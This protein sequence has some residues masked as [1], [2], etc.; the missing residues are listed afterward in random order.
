MMMMEAIRLSLVSEEE[1][2]K[3]EEKEAKKEAKKKEKADKKAEKAARK[4]SIYTVNSN[5]SSTG[6]DS[7]DSATGSGFL[8]RIESGSSLYGQNAN[9]TTNGKGKAAEHEAAA[10]SCTPSLDA[11]NVPSFSLSQSAGATGGSGTAPIPL[12]TGSTDPFKRSHLRQMSNASSASSSYVEP[13]S[14]SAG[15]ESGFPTG[16]G[17]GDGAS[18]NEPMFNFRSLAATLIDETEE[19]DKLGQ[20][21]EQV[22]NTD[23][24]HDNTVPPPAANHSETSENSGTKE[25]AVDSSETDDMTKANDTTTTTTT[26]IAPESITTTSQ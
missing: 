2:R 26:A 20:G 18:E 1:R 8:D 10:S 15:T 25:P 17:A 24:N 14:T 12:S 7:G 13:I 6:L 4:S 19:D 16:S 3:K 21:D 11:Q 9:T 5:N 23:G 22:E